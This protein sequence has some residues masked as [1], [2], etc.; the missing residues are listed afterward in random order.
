MSFSSVCPKC[1]T[2]NR[3][4][5]KLE[6]SRVHCEHC[7]KPYLAVHRVDGAQPLNDSA[8][9]EELRK[10][11]LLL[12]RM[13]VARFVWNVV[14]ALL[15]TGLFFWVMHQIQVGQKDAGGQMKQLLN[16]LQLGP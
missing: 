2:A 5:D 8:V 12:H 4:A 1:G 9:A 16:G 7:A 11:R 3:F 14:L 6:G 15:G 13:V 10:L